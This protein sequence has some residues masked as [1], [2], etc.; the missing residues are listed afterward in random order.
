MP[1]FEIT[2]QP[3]DR[4]KVGEPLRHAIM[5]EYSS[6]QLQA[7][8]TYMGYIDIVDSSG[9]SVSGACSRSSCVAV[10]SPSKG[11]PKKLSFRFEDV[12]VHK[13]GKY[14]FTISIYDRKESLSTDFDYLNSKNTS[15]FTATSKS[16]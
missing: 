15:S 14:R 3:P 12:M 6:S 8:Y 16:K 11:K 10:Q 13:S 5:A 9:N 4:V 2:R 1:D 7:G